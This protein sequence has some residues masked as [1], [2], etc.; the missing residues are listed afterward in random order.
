MDDQGA[1]GS[2]RRDD[3]DPAWGP[4]R[5]SSLPPTL[6]PH[7]RYGLNF[8][9]IV[10]QDVPD[11]PNHLARPH[12]QGHGQSL[13]PPDNL[14]R[15]TES[16]PDHDSVISVSSRSQ[17]TSLINHVS[18][19]NADLRIPRSTFPGSPPQQLQPPT[20]PSRPS[21]GVSGLF[22]EDAWRLSHPRP[23]RL[24]RLPSLL[25][26]PSY[27]G[28]VRVTW[29]WKSDSPSRSRTDSS[30]AGDLNT[31]GQSEIRSLYHAGSMGKPP[32][33]EAQ[34]AAQDRKR[35]QIW[36]EVRKEAGPSTGKGASPSLRSGATNP[37][38]KKPSTK[39]PV[40]CDFCRSKY[41]SIHWLFA[42]ENLIGS[43]I[44]I[45]ARARPI[46]T[47]CIQ[48]FLFSCCVGR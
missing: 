16:T 24:E 36:P 1:G 14:L 2:F 25:D 44:G 37:T 34:E 19:A 42:F 41:I 29:S 27:Q 35:A 26:N 11:R 32:A 17:D 6:H 22:M 45:S 30:F 18:V 13:P 20:G 4:R 21:S 9:E 46:A 28:N 5:P 39:V 23:Q 7:L 15:E 48:S 8:P 38:R 3:I 31:E 10:L 12:S 40:A 47:H 33:I 43:P